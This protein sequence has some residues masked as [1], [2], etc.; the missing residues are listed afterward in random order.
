[1][2]NDK[3][4]NI[5]LLIVLVIWI[6]FITFVNIISNIS[7]VNNNLKNNKDDLIEIKMVTDP[8]IVQGDIAVYEITDVDNINKLDCTVSVLNSNDVIIDAA[9]IRENRI[10]VDTSPLSE[11]EY[12]IKI[13][14][15]EE[16][17]ISKEKFSIIIV[18]S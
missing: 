16:E 4:I 1:M 3:K 8:I 17:M 14:I 2:K 10:I 13:V 6:L 18:K 11:G 9:Y 7:F 12:K 5:I 15:G